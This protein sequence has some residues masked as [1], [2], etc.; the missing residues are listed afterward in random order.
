MADY[1]KLE[2]ILKKRLADD[3]ENYL[4]TDNL[5]AVNDLAKTVTILSYLNNPVDMSMLDTGLGT[6]QKQLT[7]LDSDINTLNTN[8]NTNISKVNT[9]IDDTQKQ[10]SSLASEISTIKSYQSNLSSKINTIASV[11]TTISTTISEMSS[12]NMLDKFDKCLD[13]YNPDYIPPSEES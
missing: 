7:Q 6:I 2:E 10:L 9:N 1:D 13:K 3:A 8:V 5:M 4:S 11:C 12:R